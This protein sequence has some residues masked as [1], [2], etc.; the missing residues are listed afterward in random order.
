MNNMKN[1]KFTLIELLV[2]IAI[3]AILA[4]MLLPA[5]SAARLR[6]KD[7][8]C[9]SQ[10]KQM[11]TATMLYCQDNKDW[12]PP[13]ITQN[14]AMLGWQYLIVSYMTGFQTSTLNEEY[15]GTRKG[16]FLCPGEDRPIN[17]NYP[18]GTF[19]YAHYT[20]NA[21]LSGR[22][23][24]NDPDVGRVRTLG[25]IEDP[26]KAI[27]IFDNDKTDNQTVRYASYGSYRHSGNART[28]VS[29]A[30]NNNDTLNVLY[31]GGNVESRNYASLNSWTYLVVGFDYKKGT[32]AQ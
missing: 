19:K 4:A 20:I 6:A 1:K 2:V 13:A 24:W 17:Y 7:T 26:T 10:L 9:K 31:I 8:A 12:I 11:G 5:L 3:I 30:V 18:A 21:Y 14:W 28:D 32:L 23:D 29:A 27:Y 25:E 15:V 16:A 22:K